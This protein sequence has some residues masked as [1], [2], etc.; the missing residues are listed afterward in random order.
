VIAVVVEKDNVVEARTGVNVVVLIVVV[1]TV[2]E[3]VGTD[4]VTV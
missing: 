4:A 1:V 2:N 3:E